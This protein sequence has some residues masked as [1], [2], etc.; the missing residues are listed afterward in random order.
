MSCASFGSILVMGKFRFFFGSSEID[1][2]GGVGEV[3]DYFQRYNKTGLA[4]PLLPGLHFTVVN[5]Q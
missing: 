2:G 4:V 5:H 1:L 3:L